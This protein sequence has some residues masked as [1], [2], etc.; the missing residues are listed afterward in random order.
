MGLKAVTERLERAAKLEMVIDLTVEDN[1]GITILRVDRLIASRQ[2]DDLE[3]S[4]AE[5]AVR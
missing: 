4:C 2:V 1:R 3:T 5:T